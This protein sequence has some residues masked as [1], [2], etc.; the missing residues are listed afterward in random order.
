[1]NLV[2]DLVHGAPDLKERAA[3]VVAD[4]VFFRDTA[5]DLCAKR[6]QRLQL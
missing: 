6:R 4:L 1:M 5:A 3:G 2:V